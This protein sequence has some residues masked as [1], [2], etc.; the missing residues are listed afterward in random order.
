MLRHGEEMPEG[1]WV[2]GGVVKDGARH[3][4]LQEGL[5]RGRRKSRSRRGCSNSAAHIL[6]GRRQ[7]RMRGRVGEEEK[8]GGPSRSTR[9]YHA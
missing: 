3:V 5:K 6:Q 1:R 7:G 2:H 4:Q 9:C 8:R